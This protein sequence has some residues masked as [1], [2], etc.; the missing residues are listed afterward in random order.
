MDMLGVDTLMEGK[1]TF[2]T[3]SAFTVGCG[4]AGGKAG[5]GAGGNC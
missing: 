5:G 3:G 1:T 2:S 4:R